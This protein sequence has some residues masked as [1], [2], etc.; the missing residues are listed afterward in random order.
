MRFL[1][2]LLLP[3]SLI[4]CGDP[5]DPGPCVALPCDL[6]GDGSQWQVEGLAA[7]VRAGLP[8]PSESTHLLQDF[9]ADVEWV[10]EGEGG[11]VEGDPGTRR[12]VLKTPKGVRPVWRSKAVPVDPGHRY[13]LTWREALFGVGPPKRLPRVRAGVSVEFYNVS[14]SIEDPVAWLDDP[15]NRARSKQSP[16]KAGQWRPAAGRS[17]WTLESRSFRPPPIVTHARVVVAG[18]PYRASKDKSHLEVD[19]LVLRSSPTPAWTARDVDQWQDPDDG[20]LAFHARAR[21]TAHRHATEIRDVVLAP[22]PS[23]LRRSLVVPKGAR[24]DLGY[25]LAPGSR[26]PA[27]SF[28]ATLIDEDGVR[29]PLHRG[30]VQG[31]YLAKWRDADIDL[32]LWAGDRVTLELTTTGRDAPEATL[33]AVARMAEARAVWTGVRLEPRDTPGRLAILV[34]VDTLGAK[35]ASGWGGTRKTTPNLERIGREGLHYGEARAPGPWTLPSVASY[36]TGLSPDEHGAG[37]QLGR[38][39]YDRRPLLPEFD[40]LAETLR[41]DGWDTR[42]WINNKYLSSEITRLDQGFERY[43]DYG[44]RTERGGSQAG[45]N[46]VVEELSRTAGDRFLLVHLMD[47]HL[48]YKPPKK[49]MKRFVDPTYKGPL[50]GGKNYR[51]VQD[52]WRMKLKPKKKGRKHLLDLHE[53]AV[54]FADSQ[55]G[56]VYDAAKATGQE[57]LFIATSDHGEEFWEHGSFDHGHSLFDEL[58]HVPLVVHRTDQTPGKVTTPVDVTGVF[59]TVLDFAGLPHDGSA[60]LPI[61][62]TDGP[63][64]GRPTLY[65]VRQRSVEKDGWKYIVRQQSTGRRH[66]R[67]RNDPIHLLFNMKKDPQEKK[68]RMRQAPGR[69]RKLHRAVVEESLDGYPGAWFVQVGPGEEPLEMTW[70]MTGGDGWRPDVTDFPWPADDGVE[71]KTAPLVVKRDVTDD[72]AVVSLVVHSRPTLILLEAGP[73]E[74][75]VQ[76][77]V[78]GEVVA[79]PT[80]RFAQADLLARLDAGTPG[81]L[82]GR[83]DGEALGG[84]TTSGPSEADLEALR[85]LGYMDD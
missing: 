19:D 46:G 68:N 80:T 85:A 71:P 63:V 74:G 8:E 78:D 61:A 43:I 23:T 41:A 75:D 5:P 12:L 39:H 52:L 81:A 14:R 16:S 24:L 55:V 17:P 20:P 67:V 15:T 60:S 84:S 18:G 50:L 59:G 65:G 77:T 42:A 7:A 10:V 70:S 83:L 29:H 34:V 73:T 79:L 66:R 56:R 2:L 82:I 33:D 4:G 32:E 35:H 3:W 28:D 38:D 57:L 30:T 58:L 1:L 51:A 22:A 21:H 53:A 9:E 54:A 72:T 31:P 27:V 11:S 45:M 47:P 64:H 49:F 36:L 48:P 40:T 69:A 62:D 76:V 37:E 26:G 25:G 44:I 13:T 6:L